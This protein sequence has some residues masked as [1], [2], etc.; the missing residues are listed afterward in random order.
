MNLNLG[1][2]HHLLGK[3][4]RLGNYRGQSRHYYIVAGKTA[5]F[6]QRFDLGNNKSSQNQIER[7]REDFGSHSNPNNFFVI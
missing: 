6:V 3:Y 1:H 4:R 5:V 2:W 7:A